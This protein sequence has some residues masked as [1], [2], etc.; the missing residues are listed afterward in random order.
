MSA[1]HDLVI[2]GG[3][4]VDGAGGPSFTGDVAVSDGVITTIG[5]VDGAGTQELD[6]DGLLVTPGFVDIHTHLDA[7]IGWDPLGSSSCW[8][9]VTS[10]VMGNCGMTFAPV[11]PG[12]SSMLAHMME[13]V[14]DIPASAILDGLPWNWETYGE[15]L[16]T[17][18]DM[19]LAI[20]VGGLVGH[21]ALR[22]YA[23]G[24]RSVD[25]EA[26]PT[27]DELATMVRLLTEGMDAGALGFSTSRTLRHTIPDGRH[28]PGTFAESPELHAMA[29][30]LRDA[31]RGVL[32]AAP[33]FDGDG[34]SAP[35]AHS[36]I[37]WMAEASRLSG[38]PFT[39]N[40]THTWANPEHHHLVME[41]VAQA[42]GAGAQLRPQTTTRGIGVL[43]TFAHATPFDRHG[44]WRTLAGKS[45]AER[46]A[47]IR[48]PSVRAQL[49]AD[50]STG[51]HGSDLANFYVAD[52]SPSSGGEVVA[53]FDCNPATEVPALVAA[54]GVSAAEWYLD[55][56]DRSNGS[57]IIYWPVLNQSLDAINEMLEDP[58][59]VLGLADGGAHVGQILDASQ[60]TWFLTYW[61][62]ERQI[63]SVERAIQRLSADGAA[64]FGL[65]DRGLLRPGMRADINLIDWDSLA[66]PLPTFRHDLPHG[67]GRFVQ[68]ARGYE[69]TIVGGEVTFVRGDHTGASAGVVLRGS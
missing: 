14:E 36:E 2:R 48:D 55:L 43:F 5:D 52:H 31:G 26:T 54:S 32:E 21:S 33:R 66:L 57:A 40:L 69:S 59:I 38:R 16:D 22:W 37:E 27:P 62:R 11:R 1:A 8:H 56:V 28:V 53:R 63:C 34:P 25:P 47:Y 24:E 19:A 61:V 58:N 64:L 65:S 29:A 35:R 17:V 20:N 41:L 12:D 44:S 13:S 50:G 6:A 3:T 60:P 4:I 18:D 7:Q 46:V 51:P 45:L 30:V 49:I 67:A 39:F 42:N 15:Y 9:G 23:M 10:V 68:G